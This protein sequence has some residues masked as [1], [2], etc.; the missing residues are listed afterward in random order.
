MLS[1]DELIEKLQY[2]K[3]LGREHIKALKE[4]VK[5]SDELKAELRRRL[6]GLEVEMKVAEKYRENSENPLINQLLDIH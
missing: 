3:E 5:I 4:L 6:S 1:N 2:C